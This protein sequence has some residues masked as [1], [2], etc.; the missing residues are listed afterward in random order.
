MSALVEE[1]GQHIRCSHRAFVERN[2]HLLFF[3]CRSQ[4]KEE[5]CMMSS[6]DCCEG[7]NDD[8]PGCVS[9]K[10]AVKSLKGSWAISG[11]LAQGN[12]TISSTIRRIDGQEYFFWFQ[13]FVPCI[14]KMTFSLEG[15][16]L[17][18]STTTAWI[19][20][21]EGEGRPAIWPNIWHTS[22]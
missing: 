17:I 18:K 21:Q 4:A 15:T 16:C 14:T 2:Y 12:I 1:V 8:L 9:F 22:K 10:E 5:V 13:L 6:I 11:H 7:T 19:L 20:S 3:L